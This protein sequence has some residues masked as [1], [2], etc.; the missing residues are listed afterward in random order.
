MPSDLFAVYLKASSAAQGWD[1]LKNENVEAP[2]QNT[3][4]W[5]QGDDSAGKSTCCTSLVPQVLHEV[6][7]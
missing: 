6:P 2:V 5:G 4:M 1:A 7:I 3:R